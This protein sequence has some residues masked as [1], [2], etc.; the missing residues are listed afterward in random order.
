MKFHPAQWDL[1]GYLPVFR[2]KVGFLG[3]FILFFLFVL[4]IF[5]FCFFIFEAFL[6]P[7]HVVGSFLVSR[8]LQ[9][10]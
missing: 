3:A 7:D 5:L 1:G 2:S 6:K 8:S 10:P 4:F 9:G